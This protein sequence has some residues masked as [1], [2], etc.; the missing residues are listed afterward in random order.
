MRADRTPPS[1]LPHS[2][3][4]PFG[5]R[6]RKLCE[7]PLPTKLTPAHN[8]IP[9]PPRPPPQRAT[10]QQGF[11][12]RSTND[13]LLHHLIGVFL[14]EIDKNALIFVRLL[15]CQLS[16][17]LERLTNQFLEAFLGHLILLQG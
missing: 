15:V 14:S 2:K 5:A 1:P 3:S 4:L 13:L 17:E 16:F 6:K 10:A 8:P 11:L 7:L 9:P 12:S